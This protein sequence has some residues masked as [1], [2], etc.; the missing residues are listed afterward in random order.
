MEEMWRRNFITVDLSFTWHNS[1]NFTYQPLW[2]PFLALTVYF[3]V[4]LCFYIRWYPG[5]EELPRDFTKMFD[6]DVFKFD[7]DLIP[8]AKVPYRTVPYRI[9]LHCCALCLDVFVIII[10]DAPGY[11]HTR[12]NRGFSLPTSNSFNY[13]IIQFDPV[14]CPSTS[15]R[16]YLSACMRHLVCRMIP[17]H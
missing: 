13:C 3:L 5:M 6:Y 14:S 9:A 11:A 16:F 8:Q 1:S 2:H 12:P 4:C 17:W 10:F 15:D 7:V